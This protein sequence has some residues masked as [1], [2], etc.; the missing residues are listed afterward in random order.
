MSFFLLNI[1]HCSWWQYCCWW[2]LHLRFSICYFHWWVCK[3]DTLLFLGQFFAFYYTAY[4][5]RPVYVTQ[6]EKRANFTQSSKEGGVSVNLFLAPS[7]FARE[8]VFMLHCP[9][10]LNSKVYWSTINMHVTLPCQKWGN[11]TILRGSVRDNRRCYFDSMFLLNWIVRVIF[12]WEY[13]CNKSVHSV[14]G[15]TNINIF[16]FSRVLLLWQKGRPAR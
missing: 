13:F 7:P 6:R 16:L 9:L 5:V 12:P 1:S 3:G 14:S 8:R 4:T 10:L 11:T 2:L 15:A